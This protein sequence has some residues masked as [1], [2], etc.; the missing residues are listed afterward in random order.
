MMVCKKI[1]LNFDYLATGGLELKLSEAVKIVAQ[2]IPVFFARAASAQALGV[3]LGNV[4]IC[5]P[6]YFKKVACSLVIPLGRNSMQSGVTATLN[7][8]NISLS[9]TTTVVTHVN[10]IPGQ[11]TESSTYMHNSTGH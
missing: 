11:Q 9:I 3:C 6:Q 5:Q 4:H 10:K 8:I 1:F 7:I 2:G